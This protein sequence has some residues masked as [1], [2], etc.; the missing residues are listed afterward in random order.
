MLNALV[1]LR[2]KED[3]YVNV[4]PLNEQQY[5][6]IYVKKFAFLDSYQFLFASLDALMKDYVLHKNPNEMTII[7]QSNLAKDKNGKFSSFIRN[8][9]LRKGLVPWKLISGRRALKEKRET[10]PNDLELYYSN[11]TDSTPSREE[12]DKAQEFYK[13]F[14]CKNLL[15]YLKLYCEI[16]VLIL[17]EVFCSMRK[18]IWKWAEIDICHFVGLPSAAFCVFKKLSGLNIGLIT[19]PGMLS[20]ILGAIRGGLSFAST[21]VLKACPVHDPNVHII[22]C[23]ANNLYGLCQTKKLPCGNYKFVDN[24]EKV[25]GEI[26]ANYKP[27]DNTGYI[28][29]VD[30]VS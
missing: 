25:A 23:D 18:K 24:V 4:L 5:R 7:N 14:E 12:L 19:D 16:D 6:A 8:F 1:E 11:L 21:R 27:S 29:K 17:A 13:Q 15:Q 20:T 2:K 9:L 28:F 26:L 3:I 10:L 22:F 30:L